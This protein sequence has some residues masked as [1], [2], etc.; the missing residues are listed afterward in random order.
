MK[1]R[2]RGATR[3]PTA[4]GI[5]PARAELK[6]NSVSESHLTRLIGLARGKA[7]SEPAGRRLGR[8]PAPAGLEM[9][10][11][12]W[13]PAALAPDLLRAALAHGGELGELFVE[14]TQL[15]VATLDD[16]KLERVSAGSDSG[17]GIRVV[18]ERRTA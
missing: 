6:S 2:P 14:D 8:D 12:P 18:H 9:S 5:A 15:H 4:C 16:G 1:S 7:T 17:G 11:W 10:S 3:T 13:D